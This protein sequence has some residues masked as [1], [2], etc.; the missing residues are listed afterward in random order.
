MLARSIERLLG[1]I[2]SD[3]T[4]GRK[5]APK[6]GAQCGHFMQIYRPSVS[7]D[8]LALKSE[9]VGHEESCRWV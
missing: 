3:G 8:R 4:L 1:A 6:G 5:V 2:R 9:V 7:S